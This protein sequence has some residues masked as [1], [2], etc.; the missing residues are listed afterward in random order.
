[1]SL[2][3]LTPR[4]LL[5]ET[6][7]L[8][9]TLWRIVDAQHT[10]ST[11]KI[12]D[13]V[14]EQDVLEQLLEASKPVV[15]ALAS[16]LHYLLASPFR[17]PPR[18]GGSRF[19]ADTD[20]GVFY[21]AD[22]VSTASAE[23]GYWRWRFLNDAPE[24]RSLDPVAHTA[25]KVE[26]DTVSIDLRHKPFSNYAPVWQHASDYSSTQQLART[27]RQI[28]LGAIVY[29][30]VRDLDSGWCAAILDPAAFVKRKPNPS[31]QTWWL[32][33][34]PQQVVWRRDSESISFHTDK[35][36]ASQKR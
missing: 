19:R 27:A 10:A 14:L 29:K 3:T 6:Q 18:K 21:G 28:N 23:V 25:Y 15:P 2:T 5:S 9:S 33:V 17:Y 34:T 26:I 4:A 30:S 36:N 35:W 22:S 32:S 13:D 31:M 7:Q 8:K 20:P 16:Q 1:M 24:V 12:V 11:M